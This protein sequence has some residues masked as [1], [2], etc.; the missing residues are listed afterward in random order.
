M[1]KACC[2]KALFFLLIFVSAQGK[3]NYPQDREAAAQRQAGT[4]SFELHTDRSQG[5]ESAPHTLYYPLL[6]SCSS[7]EI[8]AR[9]FTRVSA[10]QNN[11]PC[12]NGDGNL[13]GTVTI[14][15]TS[16]AN[17]YAYAAM[18][19][20]RTGEFKIIALAEDGVSSDDHYIAINTGDQVRA[21]IDLGRACRD[22]LSCNL[23]TGDATVLSRQLLLFLSPQSNLPEG[24]D[25]NSNDAKFSQ[26]SVFRVRLARKLPSLN[27]ASLLPVLQAFAGDGQAFISYDASDLSITRNEVIALQAVL[28]PAAQTTANHYCDAQTNLA[29]NQIC[30]ALEG[31]LMERYERPRA[32]LKDEETF[33]ELENEVE[34]HLSLCVENKWGFCSLFP[35]SMAVT[36]KE[37]ETFL[38]EQSCFFFSAG[39]GREHPVI[40]DLK[41]F[42]DRV[43]ARLPGG[44]PIIQLYYRM[45]RNSA[46][47]VARN[48]TLAAITRGLG[49]LLAWPIRQWK[50]LQTQTLQ[51]APPKTQN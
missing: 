41:W 22:L 7:V 23:P 47:H 31:C 24:E 16:S 25:F 4:D 12:R 11:V 15:I 30:G 29:C 27:S 50:K 35:S 49:H 33:S 5:T 32:S 20:E 14:P 8:D 2:H 26:G 45:A 19:T 36:P 42:R 6:N 38:K 1:K 48:P 13:L 43:L 40:E 51:L 37:L 39:F 44:R 9:A 10:P 3:I 18:E 46:L 28:Y 34:H 21:T 17:G